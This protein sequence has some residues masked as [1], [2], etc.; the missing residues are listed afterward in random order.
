MP[1]RI[2]QCPQCKTYT[3]KDKCPKCSTK[4]GTTV[5]AKFSPEDKFGVYRRKYKQNVQS[6]TSR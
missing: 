2:F 6:N 5:P 1:N 3:L 4:T